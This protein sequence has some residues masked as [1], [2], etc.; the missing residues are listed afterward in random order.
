MMQKHLKLY[1]IRIN[2]LNGTFDFTSSKSFSCII[3]IALTVRNHTSYRCLG[4][5]EISMQRFFQKRFG[6]KFKHYY[7]IFEVRCA[8]L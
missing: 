8:A 6:Y 2:L 7:T 4:L 1:N 3:P 5:Y